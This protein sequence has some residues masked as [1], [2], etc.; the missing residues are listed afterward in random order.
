M[1]RVT[2]DTLTKTQYNDVRLLKGRPIYQ[3]CEKHMPNLK[4]ITNLKLNLHPEA[5]CSEIKGPIYLLS[6]LFQNKINR[7][8]S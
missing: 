6:W 1:C 8:R 2:S 3:K 7:G 5:D 4:T